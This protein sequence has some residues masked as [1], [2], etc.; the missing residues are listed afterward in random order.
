MENEKKFYR[1]AE[2]IIVSRTF[3]DKVAIISKQDGEVVFQDHQ[4]KSILSIDV[5]SNY[6]IEDSSDDEQI[7]TK[8]C[9]LLNNVWNEIQDIKEKIDPRLRLAAMKTDNAK[10]DN[11]TSMTSMT[12]SLFESEEGEK[13]KIFS[14][15]P[16]NVDQKHKLG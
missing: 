2:T 1:L 12:S 8:G 9:Q 10:T 15:P 11:M 6:N 16:T 14:R 4:G 3:L 13:A 5:Q 7:E